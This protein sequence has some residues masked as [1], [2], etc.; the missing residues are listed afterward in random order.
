VVESE[1]SFAKVE[2]K[3]LSIINL[4]RNAMSKMEQENLDQ[5]SDV[6]EPVVEKYYDPDDYRDNEED[7]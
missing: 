1:L 3:D 4:V 7:R 5:M 6:N 2:V